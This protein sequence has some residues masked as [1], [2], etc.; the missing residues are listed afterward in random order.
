MFLDADLHIHSLFS[1]ASSRSMVP[2]SILAGCRMKGL[3]AVGSGDALH[4]EWRR[5]WDATPAAG[6]LVI[7]SAEVEDAHRVHHLILAESFDIFGCRPRHSVRH[8]AKKA[9]G[10]P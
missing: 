1:I 8:G 4:G 5:M 7:P 10:H 9:V 2:S 6:V 3:A